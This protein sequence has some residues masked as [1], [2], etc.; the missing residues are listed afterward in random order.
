MTQ[1]YNFINNVIQE[2]GNQGKGGLANQGGSGSQVTQP[3]M[4]GVP[5]T[6]QPNNN[7]SKTS[8]N[9]IQPQ[10]QGNQQNANPTVNG[11]AQNNNAE[12][13]GEFNNMLQMQQK[14]PQQFQ[15]IASDLANTDKDKFNRFI[16]HLTTSMPG[17]VNQ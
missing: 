6:N 2:M 17:Q 11:Q 1:F 4:Q 15:K 5:P 10:F 7:Y 8:N 12:E 16:T 13:T 14:N 9:T 3:G